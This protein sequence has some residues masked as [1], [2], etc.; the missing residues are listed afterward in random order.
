MRRFGVVTALLAVVFFATPGLAQ[1]PPD[2]KTKVCHQCE[3]LTVQISDI[4]AKIA[5]WE[6]QTA[7]LHKY[8]NLADPNI[9]NALSDIASTIAKL[10]GKK[11]QLQGELAECQKRC[12]AFSKPPA[13]MTPVTPGGGTTGGT[14]G[15]GT[16]GG[17]KGGGSGGTSAGGAGPTGT[18]AV[19]P[20]CPPKGPTGPLTPGQGNANG[21]YVPPLIF[22]LPALPK[23]L[24]E[25]AD[26]HHLLWHM[27]MAQS[28]SGDSLDVSEVLDDMEDLMDDA[29]RDLAL[30]PS[31]MAAQAR[32]NWLRKQYD[33]YRRWE[34]RLQSHWMLILG[35]KA[36][37]PAPKIYFGAPIKKVLKQPTED[38]PFYNPKGSSY[39]PYEQGT[40][41]SGEGGF[42]YPYQP[43]GPNEPSEPNSNGNHAPD[44]VPGQNNM[45]MPQGTNNPY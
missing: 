38:S 33:F 3:W 2:E 39:Q 45:P 41:P 7:S 37:C 16:S 4:D 40:K 5:S 23:N 6:R 30:N 1:T 21:V 32:L 11:Q 43:G 20:P 17:G 36:D 19:E 35:G 27:R 12:A 8:S 13:P 26:W 31:D 42:Y 14:G 29:Y 25:R 24:L 15:S 9:Q 22:P 44:N 34:A 28:W 18:P 10:K